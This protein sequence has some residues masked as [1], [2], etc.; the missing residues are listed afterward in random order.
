LELTM[1]DRLR[2]LLRGTPG[3]SQLYREKT[4][5]DNWLMLVLLVAVYS[6]DVAL[7]RLAGLT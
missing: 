1:L 2:E 7:R 3:T 5:W 6:L 4:L